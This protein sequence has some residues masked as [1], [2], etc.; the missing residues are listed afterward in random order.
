MALA[1]ELHST[2][3]T[4]VCVASVVDVVGINKCNKDIDLGLKNATAP[5]Y[6]DLFRYDSHQRHKEGAPSVT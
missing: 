4:Q 5:L 2:M 6:Q 1:N 3:D